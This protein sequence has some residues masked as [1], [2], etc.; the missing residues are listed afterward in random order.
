MLNN[1]P[2]Q[3]PRGGGEGVGSNPAGMGKWAAMR[4]GDAVIAG[5][6][7]GGS[8]RGALIKATRT[9]MMGTSWMVVAAIAVGMRP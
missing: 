8:T 4:M 2:S 6:G 1:V 9:T 7:G 5:V 3:A